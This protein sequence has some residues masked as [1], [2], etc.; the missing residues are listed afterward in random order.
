MA[1]RLGCPQCGSLNLRTQ[2]RLY[3]AGDVVVT[4]DGET[5][6][7]DGVNEV[8]WDTSET[9]GIAC[10]DCPWEYDFDEDEDGTVASV[11]IALHKAKEDQ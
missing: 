9:V 11:L 6:W 5:D 4:D 2:E 3:G 7:P 8:F 1:K 10:R